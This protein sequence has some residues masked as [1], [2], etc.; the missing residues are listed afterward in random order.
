M[1]KQAGMSALKL[2]F[3]GC[4]GSVILI[5]AVIKSMKDRELVDN[6]PS[7]E[8]AAMQPLGYIEV[9]GKRTVFYKEAD[10]PRTGQ[11]SSAFVN[12]SMQRADDVIKDMGKEMIKNSERTQREAMAKLIKAQNEARR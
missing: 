9:N 5:N 10:K 1:R 4:I 12:Q 2:I 7:V 6:S 3:I 11:T 8:Q